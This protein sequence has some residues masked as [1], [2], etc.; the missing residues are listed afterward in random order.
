MSGNGKF[1]LGNILLQ[2]RDFIDSRVVRTTAGSGGDGCISFLHL[3][4]NENAGPDGGDGGN[5]GHV[6]F[7]VLI[8]PFSRFIYLQEMIFM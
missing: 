5:G 3:L 7:K 1:D 6:I 8:K 2:A 4:R